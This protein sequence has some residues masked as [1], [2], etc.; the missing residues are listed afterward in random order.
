M[1]PIGIVTI[2]DPSQIYRPEP[3][4]DDL[5]AEKRS[6]KTKEN[7]RNFD[8]NLQTSQV[9]E[10]YRLMHENQTY[11]TVKEKREKWGKLNYAEMTIIEAV[12]M[13]DNLVD[14]SDPDT[15][16]PN[17]VHAFQTAERIRERYPDDD[18]FHLIGLLHDAGKVLA[19]WGEPQHFVVGDTFPL[20]CEFQQSIVFPD[21][22]ENNPDF[23]NP[24]YNTKLGCYE[25]N[26]GIDNVMISWGHDEY[27]Y[28]V[29]VGNNC[30]IPQE[31]LD[32][33][34]YHSFYPWHSCGDYEW[35]CSEKDKKALEWVKRFNEFDLYSKSDSVPDI[36]ALM[37]YYQSL[38]DK[39]C[40]GKLKW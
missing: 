28:R 32:M 2:V 30:T 1:P 3:K 22:F 8:E 12:M 14:S 40:P 19:L 26:C 29:L 10:T 7:F 13:L 37:P 23:H 24:E 34:R 38:I 35:L 9:R 25:Q 36:D 21:F 16:L 31:G 5:N 11:E 18:W 20:G 39:Y 15:D 17:S 27:M 4:Y 6:Q 33:V